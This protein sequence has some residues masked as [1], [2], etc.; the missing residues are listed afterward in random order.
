M[1]LGGGSNGCLCQGNVLSAVLRSLRRL[2]PVFRIHISF[3]ADPDPD[4]I[5]DPKNVHMVRMRIR[6]QGGKH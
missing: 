5:Q 6:I 1:T 2:E 3:H 4:R